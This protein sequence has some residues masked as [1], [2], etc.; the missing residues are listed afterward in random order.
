M[1]SGLTGVTSDFKT[2]KIKLCSRGAHT[3]ARPLFRCCDLDINPMTLKLEVDLD[4]LKMYLYT[5]NKVAM[6][7]HSKLVIED[8]VHGG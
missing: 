6:L 5:E 2:L 4:I 8:D 3:C 1:L 7:R